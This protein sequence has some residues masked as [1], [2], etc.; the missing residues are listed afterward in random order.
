VPNEAPEEFLKYWTVLWMGFQQV[1]PA[2]NARRIQGYAF[3]S[4]SGR[5]LQ[6]HDSVR[7]ALDDFVVL[8]AKIK[9]VKHLLAVNQ[10]NCVHQALPSLR[11]GK[12][13]F[14]PENPGG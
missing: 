8:T 7:I 12:V 3:E 13:K 9:I 6:C 2:R 5:T 11:Q 10:R 4:F 1:S 14:R